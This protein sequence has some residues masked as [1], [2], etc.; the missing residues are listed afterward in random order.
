LT[1]IIFFVL[2]IFTHAQLVFAA[3]CTIRPAPID[4][5]RIAR[6]PQVK[7][8]VIAESRLMLS[9]LLKDGNA[10]RIIHEGCTH[11]GAEAAMWLNS[12]TSL[13]DVQKWL[14]EAIKLARIAFDPRIAHE[15]ER[16]IVSGKY[17]RDETGEKRLR[18]SAAPAG[19]IQYSIVVSRAEQGY[20][21]VISYVEG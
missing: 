18:L 15:V 14:D 5:K 8:H 3:D 1:Q 17:S 4:E 21:L 20:V 6:N 10:V 13:T 16:L 12:S 9:A 19:Y 7:A 2:A 11:S